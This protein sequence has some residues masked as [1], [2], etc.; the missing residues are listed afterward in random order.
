V[1]DMH[2]KGLTTEPRS[3]YEAAIG[4]IAANFHRP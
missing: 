3:D 1:Y 2:D 4:V